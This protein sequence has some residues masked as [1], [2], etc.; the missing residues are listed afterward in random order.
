MCIYKITNKINKKV[1]IGQTI[2]DPEERWEE[3][4]KRAYSNYPNEQKKPLYLAIRKYG[5]KNFEFKVIQKNIK[6]RE[7]LDKAEIYWIHFYN[8]YL[9]GYNATFGGQGHREILPIQEIIE[10]YHKTRSMNK[11]G[12]N[13]GIACDTVSSILKAAGVKPYTFRQSAGKRI[14]ISKDGFS[15]EFDSVKDCA[16]WFVEQGIPRTKNP[17]SVRTSLKQVRSKEGNNKDRPPYY[18]GYLIE[19]I[20]E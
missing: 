11:T 12:K 4:K 3:H 7:E 18:Y 13:F 16:E 8:S 10:D 9:H 2:K 1:Y 6:T 5:I 17:E 19:D 20:E 15:K 14:K